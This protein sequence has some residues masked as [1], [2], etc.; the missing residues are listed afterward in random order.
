[1]FLSAIILAMHAAVVCKVDPFM[2]YHAPDEKYN[3]IISD[4]TQRYT[5]D[6]LLRWSDYDALIIG[7]STSQNIQKKDVD[8]LWGVNSHKTIY[9][10]GTLKEIANGLNTALETHE[11]IK[12][13][14]VSL[15]GYKLIQDKNHYREDTYSPTYLYDKNYFND[16]NYILNKDVLFNYCLKM[17]NKEVPENPKE[18]EIKDTSQYEPY[19]SDGIL[20]RLEEGPYPN[21]LESLTPKERKMVKGNIQQNV[22]DIVN[23]YPD[24]EFYYFYPPYSMVF[25]AN[26]YKEGGL[27]KRLEAEEI[28]INMLL[29]CDNVRLFSYNGREDII[30]DFSNYGDEIHYGYWINRMILEDMHSGNNEITKDNVEEYLTNERE[31]ILEKANDL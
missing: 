25:W 11:D 5:N 27:K 18:I 31:L 20:D 12:V 3:Y 30:C 28:A 22:I 29:Q 9:L 17:L 1:M 26:Q 13:A 21:K 7:I 23:S 19:S 16:L 15:D 10:G 4:E 24:T 8:E 2:H 6:G 14:I